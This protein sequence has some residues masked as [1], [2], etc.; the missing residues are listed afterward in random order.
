M[1]KSE[2]LREIFKKYNLAYDPNNPD[3]KDNDVYKHK[4]YTIITRGGIQK[5]ERG[6]GIKTTIDVVQAI[7]TPSN[8]TMKGVGTLPDGTSYQTFAS[9]SEATSTNK[10]YAEM[11]EKRVRSRLILTLAGLYEQGV[12]GQDEADEFNDAIKAKQ[13][14]TY[15]KAQYKG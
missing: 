14:E 10:Y 1:S 8:V 11:A 15:S 3:S 7:S 5:I 6:S 9:A 13:S 4:H 2:L 12:F